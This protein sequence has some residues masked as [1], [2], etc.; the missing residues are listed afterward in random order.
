VS[1]TQTPDTLADERIIVMIQNS[2]QWRGN[3][4]GSGSHASLCE[5]QQF[6]DWKQNSESSLKYIGL[7]FCIIFK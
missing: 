5:V 6:V 4:V 1:E 2:A 7:T 3:G